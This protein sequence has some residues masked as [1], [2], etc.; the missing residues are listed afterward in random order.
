MGLLFVP[1]AIVFTP[2]ETGLVFPWG[3]VNPRTGH[4][5]TITDYLFVHTL[6]RPDYLLAWPV[7]VVLYLAALLSA[8]SG[9]VVGREDRRLTGG[10]LL[11]AGVAEL[12]FVL[13]TGRPVGV[14][15]LPVGTAL[16]WTIAWWVYADDLREVILPS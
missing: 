15:T 3:L 4:V 12:G 10:L 8:L 13:G 7:G 6:G 1:W 11:F 2:G 9:V 14:V 5:T 16:L